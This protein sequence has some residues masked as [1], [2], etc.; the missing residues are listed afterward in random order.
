MLDCN[1]VKNIK[2]FT[3]VKSTEKSYCKPP[4]KEATGY[5]ANQ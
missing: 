4:R 1:S 3:T 2:D 5:N